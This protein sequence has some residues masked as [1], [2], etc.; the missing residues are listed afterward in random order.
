MNHQVKE[1]WK[2]AHVSEWVVS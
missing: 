2:L 1:F